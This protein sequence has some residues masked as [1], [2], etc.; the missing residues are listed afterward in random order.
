[1]KSERFYIFDGRRTFRHITSKMLYSRAN[2]LDEFS[3]RT[4]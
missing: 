3:W 2:V 4:H 1:M